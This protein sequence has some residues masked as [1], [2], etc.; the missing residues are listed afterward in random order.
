MYVYKQ[1]QSLVRCV[2]IRIAHVYTQVIITL[3]QM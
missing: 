2:Y 1:P 3:A